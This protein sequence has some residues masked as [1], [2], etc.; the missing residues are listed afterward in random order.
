M[1]TYFDEFSNS[2]YET[3]DKI[4]SSSWKFLLRKRNLHLA[5]FF[6]SPIFKSTW[7]IIITDFVFAHLYL[8]LPK[9]SFSPEYGVR[10]AR[11]EPAKKYSFKKVVRVIVRFCFPVR[12]RL[13]HWPP[14]FLPVSHRFWNCFS[15]FLA[16]TFSFS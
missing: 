7:V 13:K 6:K 1:K 4:L 16:R 2:R 5:Q 3:A 10:V 14:W 11:A 9:Q 8:L 12:G 15:R